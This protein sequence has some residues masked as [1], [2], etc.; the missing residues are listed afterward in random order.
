MSLLAGA[1]IDVSSARDSLSLI[2]GPMSNHEIQGGQ[3]LDFG[4]I[5]TQEYTVLIGNR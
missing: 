3:L 5:A 1:S 4:S 2:R